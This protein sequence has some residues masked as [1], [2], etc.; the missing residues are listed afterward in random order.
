MIGKKKI[1]VNIL[2]RSGST[3][4][5]H[6][7]IADLGGRPVLWYSV[8]EAIKSKYADAVCVST[9]SKKYAKI[10]EKAGATVP[11]LRPAKY[12]HKKATAAAASRW[13]T[14]QFEKFSGETYDYIIDWGDGTVEK[15]ESNSSQ[16][17]NY[18]TAGTLL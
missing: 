2:A 10:A 18:D 15:V 13:T 4:I 3:S 8:S 6:K 11:F 14:L 5:K 9:D 1:L 12:S 17:H 16:T 7:N